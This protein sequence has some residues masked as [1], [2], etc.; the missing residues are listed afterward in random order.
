M[1]NSSK[2]KKKLA[3]YTVQYILDQSK[4]NPKEKIWLGIG[5]GSTMQF[6][7]DALGI[8]IENQLTTSSIVVICSSLDS[9]NRCRKWK[10][11]ILT[12]EDLPKFQKLNYYIDGAD[13]VNL[14]RQCLKGLG[15]A[16]TRE[17]LISLSSKKFIIIVDESKRVDSL[18]KSAPI[19]CEVL[20]FGYV[21]TIQ[22]LIKINSKFRE[23]HLRFGKQKSNPVLTDNGNF[24][25]DI[26]LKSNFSESN[27]IQLERKI[28]QI[29]GVIETGLFA[30][31]ADLV[32]I[33]TKEKILTLG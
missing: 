6:F 5:T 32:F 25:V 33:A 14:H 23:I 10:I 8:S 12:L 17:K 2:L 20:P 24:I 15:G 22:R 11:P 18:G 21:Q 3:L 13:E 7:I 4:K 9:E 31:P 28:N 30:N 1:S 16:H 26:Y 27:L 19:V 29:P